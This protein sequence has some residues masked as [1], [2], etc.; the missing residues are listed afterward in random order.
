MVKERQRFLDFFRVGRA[1]NGQQIQPVD[2]GLFVVGFFFRQTLGQLVGLI[3]DKR[4][5][6]QKE[7]LSR[8]GGIGTGTSDLAGVGDIKGA[9]DFKFATRPLAFERKIDGAA[10]L[11][12]NRKL[13]DP[14]GRIHIAASDENVALQLK[15]ERR[16]PTTGIKL[17]AR[18]QHG[19]ANRFGRQS[20]T[21]HLP[22]QP[23][24]GIN[25][26]S[27]GVV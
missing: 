2:A 10:I 1:T 8:D 24:I 3:F 9:E 18:S 20:A 6:Q 21:R 13:A 26:S 15:A 16:P 23:V 5:V 25:G 17:P 14:V 27:S 4:R 11:N 22:E 7:S 19:V 12:V